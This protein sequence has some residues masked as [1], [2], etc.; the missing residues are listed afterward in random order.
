VAKPSR[1]ERTPAPPDP[2]NLIE[3]NWQTTPGRRET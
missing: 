1:T 3:T 2:H